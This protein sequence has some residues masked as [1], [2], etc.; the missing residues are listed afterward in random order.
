MSTSE[1]LLGVIAAAVAVMAIVQVGAII[2]GMRV[3]RRVEQ[4]A[5]DLE[6]G[7]KPLIASL[8]TL[9][10]EASRVANLA[11]GQVERFDQ[12]CS[13]LTSK[14]EQA[15]T[16]A[17]RFV[18]RPAREGVAVVAGI[19]AAISALQGMRETTRRRSAARPGGFE[20]EEES[21]FIG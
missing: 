2:A 19:R 17:Q 12:L 16:A 7:I 3:A 6:Q 1:L 8:T 15:V 21:L 9:S 13:D 11:A 10:A 14:V 20:E 18:S 5:S 4:V